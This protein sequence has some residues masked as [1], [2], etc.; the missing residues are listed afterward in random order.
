MGIQSKRY[1]SLST[2]LAQFE[3]CGIEDGTEVLKVQT[4]YQM[5][6]KDYSL[7]GPIHVLDG[8]TRCPSLSLHKAKVSFTTSHKT[9]NP[10]PILTFTP[11]VLDSLTHDG[12]HYVEELI[13]W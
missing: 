11:M 9:S 2:V 5:N 3:L 4:I 13:H 6:I 7:L 10:P 12:S 1:Y 8:E